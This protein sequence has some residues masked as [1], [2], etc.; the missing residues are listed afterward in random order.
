[1]YIRGFCHDHPPRTGDTTYDVRRWTLNPGAE[2]QFILENWG[3]NPPR[4]GW[5]FEHVWTPLKNMSSSIGMIRHPIS[6][7]INGKINKMATKAPTRDWLPLAFKPNKSTQTSQQKLRIFR[8]NLPESFPS[9]RLFRVFSVSFRHRHWRY[10]GGH[11]NGESPQKS[12]WYVWWFQGTPPEKVSDDDWELIELSTNIRVL[13]EGMPHI[14]QQLD[15]VGIKSDGRC[16]WG[17]QN[18]ETCHMGSTWF[19][20]RF[21]SEDPWNGQMVEYYKERK[22]C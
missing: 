10:C 3:K 2:A 17:S 14:I 4:P 21:R 11:N 18:K 6:P 7:N 16:F 1:M 22:L 8:E 15:H 9:A 13:L 20:H 5:T 12:Q 19:N